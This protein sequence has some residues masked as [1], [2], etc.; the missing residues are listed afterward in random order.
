MPADLTSPIRVLRRSTRLFKHPK[1]IGDTMEYHDHIFLI[2]GINQY[3]LYG[4]HLTIW[5]TCQDLNKTNY[6]DGEKVFTPIEHWREAH[7]RCKFDDERLK[8]ST[9][10]GH[11]F[12]LEG[13]WY[14]A[15][16]YSDIEVDG[17][18]I[19]IS[20]YIKPIF[21]IS[22]KEARTKLF[23]ERRKKL[24]IELV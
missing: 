17:T 22:R 12:K 7:V 6:S 9:T 14:K 21:P 10:L 4:Q 15:I 18:D 8:R 1:R 5:Y 2:I 23:H 13:S 11:V 16:E 19:D 20:F 24:Q 3:E